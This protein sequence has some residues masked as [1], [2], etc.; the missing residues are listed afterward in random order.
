MMYRMTK[1]A[2]QERIERMMFLV[3]EVGLGNEMCSVRSERGCREVLTTT[4]VVL[5]LGDDNILITAYLANMDRVTYI[6]RNSIGARKMPNWFYE[7]IKANRKAYAQMAQIDDLFGYHEYNE[8]YTF[9]KKK[10]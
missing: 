7:Q 4:G 3:T 10:A 2:S 8:K 5:V 6:W 1:H 9:Y